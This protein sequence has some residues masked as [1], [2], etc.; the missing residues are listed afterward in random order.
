M[1]SKHGQL[2]IQ[3]MSFMLVALA[4]LFIFIGLFWL[5]ISVVNIQKSY[6]SSVK[7][8]AIFFMTKIAESPELNYEAESMTV[9]A[10][11]LIVMKDRIMYQDFWP[12]NSFVIKRIYPSPENDSE[13]LSGL[14]NDCNLFT[15]KSSIKEC[16]TTEYSSFVS[17]CRKEIKPGYSYDKCELGKIIVCPKNKDE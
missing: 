12:V 13:C 2:K 7:E 9:D 15:I 17:I 1:K 4:I 16:W 11:K 6:D 10:D 14:Y 3:E 8:E 5:G